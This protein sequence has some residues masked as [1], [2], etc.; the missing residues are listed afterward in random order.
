LG[1]AVAP[2][3]NRELDLEVSGGNVVG[4]T[5]TNRDNLTA[6]RFTRKPVMIRKSIDFLKRTR[7]AWAPPA[8][9]LAAGLVWWL[10]RASFTADPLFATYLD[11]VGTLLT[12]TYAANALVRF[13]GTH[14]RVSLILAFGFVL[15]GLIETG[16]TF[17]FHDALDLP[18]GTPAHVMI[19][20]S[21]GRTLL[22]VVLLVALVVERRLPN[23]RDPRREITAAFLTVGVVGYVTSAVYLGSLTEPAIRPGSF[24]TRPWELFPAALF[25]AAAIGYRRRLQQSSTAFD[26]ALVWVA[27]FN[28]ASQLVMTQSERL[29]DAPFTVAHGLKVSS[30]ALVLCGALLDNA[31]LFDKV[32]QLAISDPLT[33]LANYRRLLD[34][35]E[36]EIQRS[37]RTGRSFAL[38]L[39][40]L[41]GLKAVNDRYGHL[42]G[43]RAICRLGIVLQ[44]NCRRLD[45]PARY[46]GDEFAVVLPESGAEA[47]AQ[48]AQRIC[49]RLATDGELPRITASFGSAVYPQNGDSIEKLFTAADRGLYRMKGR[50]SSLHSFARIASCL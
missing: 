23:A 42:T 49:D 11:L 5:V 18:P 8:I 14:D 27:W 38:L 45:T 43:S 17:G 13:R 48:V 40:D 6:E 39:L 26:R 16:G 50:S 41:D 10:R 47:A 1:P 9:L 4:L 36:F 22:A 25:L 7:W 12:F 24:L 2:L 34:T 33:G 20:W 29:L 19:T 28:V 35:L 32:R 15:T 31:R 3:W 37:R 44:E 46:G 30:Y 21:V